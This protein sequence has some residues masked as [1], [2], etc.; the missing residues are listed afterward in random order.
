[1]TRYGSDKPDL[2][3]EC[4]ILTVT[5]IFTKSNFKSFAETIHGNGVV[6]GLLITGAASFSRKEIDT[7]SELAKT[8]NAK[9]VFVWKHTD[10]GLESNINKYLTPEIVTQLSKTVK[11]QP[12]DL[13]LIIADQPKIAYNALGFIRVEVAKQLKW[14]D[15]DKHSLLWVTDF[16]LLEYNP[17]ESRYVAIHHPFTSP[18]G[19]DIDLLDHEPEKVRARAYDLVW[20]GNEIAG[21][22]IRIHRRDLQNRVFKLLGIQEE[23]AIQ[24]FGFLL[25]AFEYGAPPHGGIAFGFDRLVM[26]LTG[27]DSLR[28]VIAFPKT[29]S[30]LSLMDGAPSAVDEEQLKELG[31]K[32][33]AK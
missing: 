4:P 28:E 9:G 27:A 14:I 29:T 16:P 20:N 11:S 17:E 25:D 33:I 15:P 30:A 22:S 6:A 1:L 31:I 2:R 13:L 7:L 19:E 3:F 18:K 26:L 24:K 8:Y 5:N 12:G 10:N 32:I 23:E 21:G